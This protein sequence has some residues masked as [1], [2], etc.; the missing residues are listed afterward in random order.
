MY[1][2]VDFI[3]FVGVGLLAW[4][5]IADQYGMWSVLLGWIPGAATGAVV[6]LRARSLSSPFSSPC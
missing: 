5:E 3:V 6:G 1:R 2:T 4:A